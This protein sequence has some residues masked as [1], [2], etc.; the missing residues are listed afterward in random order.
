MTAATSTAEY[1]PPA[2]AATRPA[3]A[4]TAITN[5]AAAYAS[6]LRYRPSRVPATGSAAA[7]INAAPPA[8]A[9]PGRPASASAVTAPAA[10]ATQDRSPSPYA[11]SVTRRSRA[12]ARFTSATADNVNDQPAA[13]GCS[14]VTSNGRMGWAATRA[15]KRG[16]VSPVWRWYPAATAVVTAAT[17]PAYP[18]GEW[19]ATPNRS[20]YQAAY[21]SS[22]TSSRPTAAN[23]SAVAVSPRR[24]TSSG[25]ARARAVNPASSTAR[26]PTPNCDQATAVNTIAATASSRPPSRKRAFCTSRVDASRVRRGGRVSGGTGGGTTG[27]GGGKG[28]VIGGPAATRCRTAAAASFRWFHARASSRSSAAIPC[29]AAVIRTFRLAISASARITAIAYGSGPRPQPGQPVFSSAVLLQ[30]GQG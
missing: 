8:A 16:P 3:A 19:A 10:A 26:P 11:V 13:S 28:G 29:W 27:S 6:T 2:S 7:A 14:G 12:T 9:G 24:R 4:P 20:T 25:T 15:A 17:A 1:R 5:T 22:T 30:Y 21:P 18:Y 23:V